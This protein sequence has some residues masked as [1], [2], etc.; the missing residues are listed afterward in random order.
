MSPPQGTIYHV[1]RRVR[2]ED[3]LRAAP[4]WQVDKNLFDAEVWRRLPGLLEN[5]WERQLVSFAIVESIPSLVPRL[6]GGISFVEAQYVMKARASTSSTLPNLLF[7]A[8]M[9]GETP[10]LPPQD[11]AKQNAAGDLHLVNFLGNIGVVDLTDPELANFYATSNEG[12]LFLHSGYS[13]SA[14]WHEVWR[15]DHVEELKTQGM[16][17]DRQVIL[18][19]GTVSTLMRL[20]AEESLAKP[21]ARFSSLFFPPKPLFR[22]SAGEQQLI[23]LAIL[24]L[25]DEQAAQEICLSGD[26]VK[27]RWRS[28]YRKVDM[29]KPELLSG[30]ESSAMRRRTLLQYLR[31]HLEELRPYR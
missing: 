3:F 8:A 30:A 23:E 2:R 22:F 11:V 18:P 5:L 15:P 27:K 26:A 14:M 24:E 20:T 9:R 31:R 29:V 10:F 12:F 7:Q 1:C 4:L 6:F 28:I 21:Y 16:S 13:Y 19:N 17:V 25:S